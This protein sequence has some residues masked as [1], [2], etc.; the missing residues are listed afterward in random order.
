MNV[1]L[2]YSACLLLFAVTES[3]DY[4]TFGDLLLYDLGGAY[5]QNQWYYA[6]EGLDSSY[7]SGQ[8]K[9]SWTLRTSGTRSY[10]VTLA[11]TGTAQDYLNKAYSWDSAG[12]GLD[13]SRVQAYIQVSH[14]VRA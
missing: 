6:I 3:F 12:T 4:Y 7:Y 2:R 14:Y 8:S 10:L 13:F 1:A 11:A 5:S 9:Y